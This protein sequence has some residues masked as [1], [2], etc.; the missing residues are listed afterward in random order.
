MPGRS[1]TVR[2]SPGAQFLPHVGRAD[3]EVG[4]GDAE[5]V[6]D[7]AG[8]DGVGAEG[9]A[10]ADAPDAQRVGGGP[11][12]VADDDVGDLGAGGHEVV[13]Q[14]SAG[15][16]AGFVVDEVFV[17][18]SADALGD[19]AHDL[20]VDDLGVQGAAGVLDAGVLEDR[21]L[22]GGPVDLDGRHLGA[23]GECPPD[24]V[25]EAGCLEAR[26]E[27][28][29][30]AVG[31]QVGHP[32]HFSDRDPRFGL[33]GHEDVAAFDAEVA[34]GGFDEFGGEGDELVPDGDGGG[35]GGAA[36]NDGLP[37]GEG[38]EAPQGLVG[39]AEA[40]VDVV[41]G[42]AEGVGHDL[43]DGGFEALALGG[44]AGDDGDPP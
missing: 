21:Q 33:S 29:G 27:A 12:D 37:G 43:G 1:R 24:G 15:Q 23:G 8:Q 28:V 31:L 32:G 6:A 39:V 25:V 16:V 19:G 22:A 42:D 30:E 26:L 9:S 40:D 36:A 35:V 5:G 13:E 41:V 44:D 34:G 4:D 38:A 11:G 18:R 3:G 14:R 17:Q 2:T 20:A 10:F 7:G